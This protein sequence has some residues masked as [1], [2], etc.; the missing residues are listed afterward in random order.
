L[1]ID[2]EKLLHLTNERQQTC[3]IDVANLVNFCDPNSE[4]QNTGVIFISNVLSG[5]VIVP[6]GKNW[7]KCLID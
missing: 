1:N 7:T 3:S 5:L 2:V 6:T 4:G